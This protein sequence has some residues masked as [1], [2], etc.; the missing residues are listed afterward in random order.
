VR[1]AWARAALRPVTQV[2]SSASCRDR[3]SLTW[4]PSSRDGLLE[5]AELH[6]VPL[7]K[8]LPLGDRGTLDRAPDLIV[9][10]FGVSSRG[11]TMGSCSSTLARAFSLRS[12]R[13][14]GVMVRHPGSEIA[15]F[16]LDLEPDDLGPL[17]R[18]DD[19][20][21]AAPSAAPT[22]AAI[23]SG[24]KWR[25]LLK[26]RP[27]LARAGTTARTGRPC[28]ALTRS[29]LVRTRSCSCKVPNPI[30]S[31]SPR[32]SAN[33][34]ASTGLRPAGEVGTAAGARSLAPPVLTAEWTSSSSNR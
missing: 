14:S 21:G 29:A 26:R 23:S 27:A 12:A 18:H 10:L 13:Y 28:V 20:G 30:P 19:Q 33:T 11:C 6:A 31:G 15:V 5:L 24:W 2:R 4:A 9:R 1:P 8:R 34:D 17:Q 16:A 22:R 7:A 3:S 25:H 32:T